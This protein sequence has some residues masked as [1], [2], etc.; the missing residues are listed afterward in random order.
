VKKLKKPSERKKL[1]L[2]INGLR[3][4][5]F[6][7]VI[8]SQLLTHYFAQAKQPVATCPRPAKAGYCGD[9]ND[10]GQ[11]GERGYCH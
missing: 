6:A 9:E 11:P 1:P 3:Q 8:F 4:Q 2:A 7:L 10:R 5:I